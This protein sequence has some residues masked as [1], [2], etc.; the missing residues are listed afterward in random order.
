MT[1]LEEF[2]IIVTTFASKQEARVMAK[3]LLNAQ[4][5]S[6][7]QIHKVESLYIYE[8]AVCQEDEFRLE[9]KS[10]TALY[11]EV[12]QFIIDHHSYE[13]AEVILYE[14]KKA[15]LPYSQWLDETL[16]KR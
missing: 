4:L 10:R 13:V 1:A 5:A 7:L 8:G 11:K 16:V 12:E 3:K 9:I 15:S 14:I 6:C 2:G